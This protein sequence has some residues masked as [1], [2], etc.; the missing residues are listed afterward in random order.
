MSASILRVCWTGTLAMLS[1]CLPAAAADLTPL[2]TVERLHKAMA[3]ADASTAGSLLHVDYHGASL[4]GGS[5]PRHVYVESRKKAV[6]DIAAL[7]A[8]DWQIR[9]LRTSTQIDSH[10]MAH[11][12]G[13]YVFYYKGAPDHCGFESYGLFRDGAN[14]KIISFA[15]TDNPLKGRSVDQVCPDE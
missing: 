1:I 3:E 10:G 2:Q 12:W 13:R 4:Q 9:F 15:D 7:H 8:G 6:Q 14:W 11:V 5:E